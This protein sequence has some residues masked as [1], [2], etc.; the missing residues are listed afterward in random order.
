MSWSV[1]EFLILLLA[2]FGSLG[3]PAIRFNMSALP[4][5][6]QIATDRR[7]PVV[8]LEGI[9]AAFEFRASIGTKHPWSL[10]IDGEP[11][12]KFNARIA[13]PREPSSLRRGGL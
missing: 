9:P 3:E 6:D 2:L 4:G 8:H 10:T 7:G 1:E 12:Q 11:G 5:D 13:G